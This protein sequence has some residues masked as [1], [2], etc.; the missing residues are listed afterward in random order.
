MLIYLCLSSHGYGH[1]ARQAAVLAELHRL[2]PDWRL[3]VSSVVDM[4]FLSLVLQDIPVEHRRLR[5]DVGMV[6]MNAIEL[7][8]SSTLAALAELNSLL[9][10][11]IED[12][13]VWIKAQ[14]CSVIVLAD[15]PPAAAQLA[16]Q[17]DAPLVWMGNFGWDEIYAPLGGPFVDH[18]QA[19]Y[20]DYQRGDL[21]LRCPFS[22]SMDWSTPEQSLGLTAPRPRPL[23]KE[24]QDELAS[25]N[26]PIVMVGFGGFGL[27]LSSSLFSHWPDHYFLVPRPQKTSI[28]MKLN[29]CH[30]ISFLPESSRL[31]DALPFCSRHIG[32]PG[33]SSFCEAISLRIGL[34]VV[35]RND[36]AETN[37]LLYGLKYF[38]E[39]RLLERHQLEQGDW[40]L[41]QPLIAPLDPKGLANDG[42]LTAANSLIEILEH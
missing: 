38:A 26:S 15:I 8:C 40:E 23:P 6:Q 20:A 2:Q 32:K 22:L 37:A 12:E 35:R 10:T 36:F 16:D 13:V 25:I 5:W 31:L 9:P 1:A 27:P 21:L 42:A 41:D 24:K 18:A 3:V 17:L 33:Y 19:A 29:Q 28:Y 39:H 7:D 11:Q 4:Q 14:Q 30:N 34:H